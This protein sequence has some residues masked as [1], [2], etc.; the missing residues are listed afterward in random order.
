MNRPLVLMRTGFLLIA[1]RKAQYQLGCRYLVAGAD[2]CRADSV[3]GLLHCLITQ[4]NNRNTRHPLYQRCLDLDGKTF[5]P[6]Y[7][8]LFTTVAIFPFR[9]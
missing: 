1:R 6:I 5:D 2:H 4:I 8:K 7:R 9:I 3:P